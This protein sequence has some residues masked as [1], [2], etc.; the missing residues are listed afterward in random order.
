MAPTSL[1][2]K[3]SC[4]GALMTTALACIRQRF[5]VWLPMGSG[6]DE[7]LHGAGLRDSPMCPLC[8]EAPGT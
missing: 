6:G 7:R 3:L 5:G 4:P 1:L 8:G 2:S